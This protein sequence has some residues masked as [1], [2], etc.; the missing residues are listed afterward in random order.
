MRDHCICNRLLFPIPS[1]G[2]EVA[3]SFLEGVIITLLSEEVRDWKSFK[4]VRGLYVS[5]GSEILP[6][7]V[8]VRE[9]EEK[10]K[11][12]TRRVSNEVRSNRLP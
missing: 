1:P 5:V 10:E 9:E 3:L 6:D 7:G 2:K 11:D 12:E 8:G 4:A